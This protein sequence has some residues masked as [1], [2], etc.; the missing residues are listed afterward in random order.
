MLHPLHALA[1]ARTG[2]FSELLLRCQ[3]SGRHEPRIGF[4]V[5]T[6]SHGLDVVVALEVEQLLDDGRE[7]VWSVSLTTSPDSFTVT[8]EIV[9]D[10]AAPVF[11]KAVQTADVE[12]AA[13]ALAEL[14]RDVVDHAHPSS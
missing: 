5:R 4:D 12:E 1:H 11:L 8:G 9:V 14:A 2:P 3:Q 6:A 7:A 13:A 10:E